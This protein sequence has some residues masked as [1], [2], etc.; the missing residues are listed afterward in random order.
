VTDL[1][2]PPD[3]APATTE[4]VY[5][6]GL[7]ARARPVRLQVLAGELLVSGEGVSLQ[8]PVADVQ[9]PERTRHGQRVA[10]L[11]G[12]GSLRA[13]DAAAWDHWAKTAGLRESLVV[14]AQQNWRST[15]AAVLGL[16][17]MG[18]A[19]YAWGVPWLGRA[20]LVVVPARVD[21]AIGE[22]AQQSLQ[23]YLL[24]PSQ[25]PAQRQQQVREAF[26]NAVARADPRHE[27][28]AYELHFATSATVH[29][30]APAGDDRKDKEKDKESP[31]AKD[32][33]KDTTHR[34]RLGPNAFALPGGIVFVTDDMLELLQG[35]DD[36][37]IGVLAHEL[38]HVKRRHGMRLVV[39]AT[40]L[41]A[42]ASL[43]WG[44]FSTLLATVPVLLGQ[45]AYSRDFEREAD[46]DA[47]AMLRA[48]GISPAV[49]A[50][51]FERLAAK[52]A[53]LAQAQAASGAAGKGG[54]LNGDLGI[55]FASHPDDAERIQRFRDAAR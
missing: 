40:V 10:H 4:A 9:W 41:G 37:L 43:V 51:M 23:A 17:V 6:D 50:E 3:P 38:G 8:V 44:D 55:A 35:R 36:V 19:T 1:D 49:M 47:I 33:D 13:A 18:A 2:T 22:A 27:L 54:L 28:P 52:R 46:L 11:R 42:A 30:G 15:L 48:N 34:T 20:A 24:L 7:S 12:G 39:Q 25:V 16:L 21:L 5:F 26:A 45:N 14:K 53:A 29:D 31:A 32:G